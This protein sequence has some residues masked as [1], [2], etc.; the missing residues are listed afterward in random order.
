MLR[1][2]FDVE[3]QA[4]DRLA[5]AVATEAPEVE[6]TA[7]TL[8]ALGRGPNNLFDLRER[9]LQTIALETQAMRPVK[10]SAAALSAAICL[11][12]PV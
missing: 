9:E 5:P 8:A 10:E 3:A 6:R 12:T 2:L 11:K 1:S 4:L 7:K